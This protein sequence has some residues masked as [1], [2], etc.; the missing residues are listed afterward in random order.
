[1]IKETDKKVVVLG[2]TNDVPALMNACD[3]VIS[4]PG[5]LKSKME[6]DNNYEEW[7]PAFVF[8]YISMGSEISEVSLGNF[9]NINEEYGEFVCTEFE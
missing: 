7:S 5:G 4:K 2:Y 6:I 1:M 3:F 8:G 9:K